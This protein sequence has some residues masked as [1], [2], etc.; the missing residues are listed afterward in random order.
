VVPVER[1]KKLSER[2]KHKVQAGSACSVLNEEIDT[3]CFAF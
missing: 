1:E 2:H 3:I